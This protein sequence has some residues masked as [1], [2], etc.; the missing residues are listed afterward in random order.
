M[1]LRPRRR[2]VLAWLS[3]EAGALVLALGAGPRVQAG[4]LPP[5]VPI[6]AARAAVES[7]RA[8]LIDVR[9]P[10]ETAAGVV[11]GATLVPSG[12][13][14]AQWPTVVANRDQPVLLICRTSNRSKAAAKALREQGY[15]QVQY[16]EGGMA[17]WV[18]RGWPTA[19]PGAAPASA[20]AR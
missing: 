14:A 10:D 3:L 9:E 17:E 6:D 20:P 2:R 5:S 12:Q 7:G 13:L 18:K 1:S 4:E 19:A 16:V 8:R 11:P 15:T